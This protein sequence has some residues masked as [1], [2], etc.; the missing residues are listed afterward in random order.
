[1][2]LILIYNTIIWI[3]GDSSAVEHQISNLMVACSIH[4]HRSFDT[5]LFCKY[6]LGHEIGYLIHFLYC[7]TYNHIL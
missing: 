4:V 6:L 2:W 1:M 7:F 3:G 5:I